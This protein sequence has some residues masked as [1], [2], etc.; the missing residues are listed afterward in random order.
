VTGRLARS[1]VVVLL[2]LG[3][4]F[5]SPRTAAAHPL[6]TT[7]V[8]LAFAPQTGTITATV[9]VFAD[10]FLNRAARGTALK[11][12]ND[13]ALQKLTLAYLAQTLVLSS[14]SG[15]AVTLRFCGWKRSADLI[16]ICL[17]GFSRKGIAGLRVRDAILTDVFGDQ[18]NVV[19][20][21]YGGR[22][23]SL[24]FVGGGAKQLP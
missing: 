16:F 4:L 1:L 18:V 12:T 7:F 9:K 5:A 6:H 20:A 17:S 2:P 19:Q 11:P 24:L 3:S 15:E 10:D 21:E 8:E 22:R 13:A 23:H 14:A